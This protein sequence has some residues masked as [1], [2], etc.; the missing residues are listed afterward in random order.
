MRIGITSYPMLF[1][2]SGGLQVQIMETIA[3][4]RALGHRVEL[5]ETHCARPA[6]V[7]LIHVFGTMNGNYRLVEAAVERGIPVVLSSLVA[8]SWNARTRWGAQL[9]GR[10]ANSISALPLHST[11][12]QIRQALR[13]AH[14][15]IA[16]GSAEKTAIVSG[17][18]IAQEKVSLVPNGISARFF[19]ADPDLFR[20]RTR[21]KGP[22]VLCVG[23][24]SPYKNQLGLVQALRPLG[25]PAV[26]IGHANREHAD[27]LNAVLA[28]P[29]VTWLGAL[30]H[31]DPL[32]ASA[33]AAATVLALPSRGEV[34]P[35]VVL[36]ALGAGTPVVMTD[37]SAL[38]LPDSDFALRRV[39][40]N[41]TVALSHQIACLCAQRP[42]RAAVQA[43]VRDYSWSRV[44][45]RINTCYE[46]C[47]AN[48]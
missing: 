47:H 46:A 31:D 33:Y 14:Q 6:D 28:A 7:D 16:L 35:L 2:R 37:E 15:I 18:G 40:W 21:V 38:A 42:P 27:H 3:A 41:D 10:I 5:M 48:I 19:D 23:M 36:E 8:P 4:L 34:F 44:A 30:G 12:S 1:Q 29:N 17:F 32:L 9:A 24:L 13:L 25:L 43:L 39:H 26:L 45:H 22:F 11:Y 20:Q